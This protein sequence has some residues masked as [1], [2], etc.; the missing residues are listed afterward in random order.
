MAPRNRYTTIDSFVIRHYRSQA[1]RTFISDGN[2]VTVCNNIIHH[3]GQNGA[4]RNWGM[5][6]GKFY[7]NTIF[8][9]PSSGISAF[10]YENPPGTFHYPSN[11]TAFGNTIYDCTT[12]I[13]LG[14]GSAVYGNT[15]YSNSSRGINLSGGN[16]TVFNNIISGNGAEGIYLSNATNGLVY[17]NTCYD[18]TSREIF[19]AGTSTDGRLFNNVAWSK[20][21]SCIQVDS[22]S[23]NGF[24]SDYNNFCT[25]GGTSVGH[26]A[27]AAQSSLSD[28]QAASGQDASSISTDPG[29]VGASAAPPDVHLAD[30]SRSINA[31]TASFGGVSAPST[32]IDG[33]PRPLGTG[34]DQGADEVRPKGSVVLIQ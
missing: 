32:D 15:C 3:I 24:Q 10:T 30:G 9:V 11:H 27:G 22:A 13:S 2:Y 14:R 5:S 4:I 8:A 17:N 28:W 31:G 20:S 21:T 25:N 23:T 16:Q 33:E 19:F 34:Y 12:A 1:I 18:N 26:W 6:F 29:F 7:S